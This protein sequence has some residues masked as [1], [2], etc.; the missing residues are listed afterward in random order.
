MQGRDARQSPW[1]AGNGDETLFLVS[2]EAPGLGCCSCSRQM[3]F[4]KREGR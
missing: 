1:W 4:S 3:T 2:A